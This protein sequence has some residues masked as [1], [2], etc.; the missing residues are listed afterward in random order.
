MNRSTTIDLCRGLLFILMTNAHA[1]TIAG[2][3]RFH[4]LRTDFWLPHGWATVVFVVLSGYGVGFIFSVRHPPK[5]RDDALRRRSAEIMVVML[6][7]NV[8]FAALRQFA[9]GNLSPVFALEWWLGFIT[10]ETD[11]TISGVLLPTALV[12]LCGPVMIRWTQIA[13]WRI[14]TLLVIAR[15]LVSVL[16]SELGSSAHAENWSVRFFLLEGFGG[17]PVLPFVI[18]GCIGIWLGIQRHGNETVWRR[19]MAILLLLQIAV[20][21]TTYAPQI[22]N[23]NLFVATVGAVGKFAWMFLIAHLLATLNIRL[24][25][26]PIELLGKFAL[27]SFVMHRVFLQALG[28]G[29]GTLGLLTL[30]VESRFAIL[31]IGALVMTWALCVVRLRFVKVDQLLRHVAL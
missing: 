23:L 2:V 19:S 30:P 12:L 27:G 15:I 21:L 1:L 22:S 3:P 18:N 25:A 31:L 11:W 13:P 5:V 28:I 24:L 14:L 8:I 7:S 20:Y 10:L 16:A 26:V 4:W 29:F 6:A 17:F 9:A